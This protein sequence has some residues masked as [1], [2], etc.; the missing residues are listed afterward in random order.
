MRIR[1][2]ES[3]EDIARCFP[4]MVQLR[5]ALIEAQFVARIQA[6]QSGGYK[7][8]LL[9]DE[10]EVQAV[11]GY[12]VGDMLSRGR[13]MY[14]DDLVTTEAARSAGYGAGLFDWLVQRAQDADCQQLDLDSGVHRHS[15]HRFYFRRG[16]HIPSYHFQLR[17]DGA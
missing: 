10:G 12:R 3:C 14:V 15:A 4:V 2:A 9:E 8:V 7:L 16:M 1:H 6:L 17:L 5:P 13:H 11:A